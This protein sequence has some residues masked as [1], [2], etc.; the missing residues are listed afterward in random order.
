M[1]IVEATW[2]MRNLGKKTIEITIEKDDVSPFIK[3]QLLKNIEDQ[4]QKYEAE[5]VVIKSSTRYSQLI[6]HLQEAGFTLVENQIS[7]KLIREDAIA[8]YEE[9]KELF[10]GVDYKIA[11]KNDIDLIAD[12]IK[13]GIFVTDRIAID[14]Y[15]GV[16]IAN[17]RYAN[18]FQDVIDN[19]AVA[20]LSYYQGRIFGFG[21]SKLIKSDRIQGIIGGIFLGS[22]NKNLGSFSA[23][24]GLKHF[25]ER[26]WKR[27]DTCVSS[28]NTDVLQ[29]HLMFNKKITDIKNV[30]IKHY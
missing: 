16:E 30:F 7:L 23:F 8:A 20:T 29:L 17:K 5:Y 9:Y 28:N 21:V 25:V 27:E 1:K 22:E 3:N 13:K 26:G 12:E 19:G 6:F 15:F 24:S 4:I 10:K 11:D 2:E 18:W 14:P